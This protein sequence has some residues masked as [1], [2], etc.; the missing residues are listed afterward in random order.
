MWQG[1]SRAVIDI[2]GE[3]LNTPF[4]AVL[5]PQTRRVGSSELVRLQIYISIGIFYMVVLNKLAKF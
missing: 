2:Y 4:D 5:E 1:D 3:K